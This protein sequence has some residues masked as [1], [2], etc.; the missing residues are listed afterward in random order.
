[1]WRF[2]SAI[3]L[4][5]LCAAA[6]S[7]VLAVTASAHSNPCHPNHTCP[8]DHHTYPWNGLWCTSYAN[9]RLASDTETVVYDGRTYWCHG[10]DSRA[11]APVAALPETN[12]DRVT[13]VVDGDTIDATGGRVRLVQ[14]DTPEVYFGTECYGPQASALAKRLLPVGTA[15]RLVTEPAGD[16]VDRYGRLLRYVVRAADGLNVNTYLVRVGAAAPYFYDGER[17]RYAQ[18]LDRLARSAHARHLGLWGACPHT[19]YDPYEGVATRQ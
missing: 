6:A 13:R 14:I 7:A 9:E 2:L 15:V 8:S 11:K 5:A 10:T 4:L 18:L 12:A 3:G 16:R 1:V 19:P 17:G